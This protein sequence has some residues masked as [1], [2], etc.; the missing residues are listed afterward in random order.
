M[1]RAKRVLA[2]CAWFALVGYDHLDRRVGS[3]AETHRGDEGFEYDGVIVVLEAH[4]AASDAIETRNQLG[5][6]G[7]LRPGEI[8]LEH[9]RRLETKG[10][11]LGAAFDRAFRA[12]PE[13]GAPLGGRARLG[14]VA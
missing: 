9:D 11:H 6:V 3:G 13:T 2:E 8:D 14:G 5:E 7:V 10:L 1:E 12:G 4:A